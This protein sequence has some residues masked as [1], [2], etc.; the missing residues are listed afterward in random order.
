MLMEKTGS[1]HVAVR[2]A[3][4]IIAPVSTVW[5]ERE[6]LLFLIRIASIP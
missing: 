2:E 6:T 5:R 1:F 3:F 4:T